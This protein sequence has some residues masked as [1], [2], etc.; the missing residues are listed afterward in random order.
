MD[1]AEF[2][3]TKRCTAQLAGFDATYIPDALYPFQREAVSIS[4]HRGRSAMFQDCGMGKTI[5]QITW[6]QNVHEHT[7]KPVLIVAPLA[8]GPQT[9][10]EGDRLL[11]I[12]VAQVRDGSQIKNGISVTNYEMLE[13]FD[14]S[15]FGGIVLDESGILKGYSGKFRRFV[16]D[17]AAQIPYRLPCSATPAP[18][19]LIEIINHAEFLGVLRGKEAIAMFFIQDGNTT[20]K[21]RLKGHAAR[22]FWE[23]VAGWAIAMQ[24]PS[25]LG[26]FDDGQFNLPELRVVQHTVGGHVTDGFLFPIEAQTL[27]ERSMARRESIGERVG[28]IADIANS[29]TDPMIVWCGL[30]QESEALTAAING[31]VE[32]RGSDTPDQ[33]SERMMGFTDGA[34]R[35][36]V[37]KPSIA[38]HG[39][40]WQHCNLMG[41]VGLSDSYEQYYQAVRRCWRYGQKN[42]V[43]AHIACADTEGAVLANIER[44]D[45]QQHEM[46][47][48]IVAHMGAVWHDAKGRD[49]YEQQQGFTLPNWMGA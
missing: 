21:W 35:V 46:M 2:L 6:A 4:T 29:T 9:A 28:V 30:N 49:A 23:W 34:H 3:S 14:A 15:E 33:K 19:D 25:D 36:I 44:K 40:N 13:R 43:T 39:M 27:Q 42:P 32:V 5:Q 17:F 22:P 37:T 24:K 10:R 26:P 38:G 47:K 31:A 18:N 12:D 48:M 11:N 20:H 45:R 16:T 1:Y 41:F 7:A 8:V